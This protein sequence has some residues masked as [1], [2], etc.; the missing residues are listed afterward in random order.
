[1]ILIWIEIKSLQGAKIKGFSQMGDP[2][3]DLNTPEATFEQQLPFFLSNLLKTSKHNR[4]KYAQ[5][6]FKSTF[7]SAYL[8]SKKMNLKLARHVKNWTKESKISFGYWLAVCAD[9]EICTWLL[10]LSF[11]TAK[12]NLMHASYKFSSNFHA[13][14]T[15]S[16]K[17]DL[18]C[19]WNFLTAIYRI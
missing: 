5:K 11:I 16:L 9:N 10:D 13:K 15:I 8:N 6:H 7:G 19:L 18:E 2:W 4:M 12:I 14:R 1:M 3:G 17:L